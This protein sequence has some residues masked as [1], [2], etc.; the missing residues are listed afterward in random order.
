MGRIKQ[1]QIEA[2]ETMAEV[3]NGLVAKVQSFNEG[4]IPAS[5]MLR[6]LTYCAA[7]LAVNT[8][9]GLIEYENPHAEQQIDADREFM[10]HA[11][12]LSE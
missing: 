9:E 11:F 6:D 10:R 2:Q 3:L 8:H 7:F 1:Q 5:E 4:L 12:G